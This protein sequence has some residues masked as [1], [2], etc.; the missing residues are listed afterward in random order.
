M[1]AGPYSEQT[2][3]TA[4][5]SKMLLQPSESVTIAFHK[6]SGDTHILNFLSAATLKILAKGDENFATAFPK[7]LDE[8]QMTEH[9][10]PASLVKRTILELDELGL[11]IP[12]ETKA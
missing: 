8:I 7:I 5:I 6:I 12:V 1:S 2:T 11:V 4:D 10:C 3:W 9:D